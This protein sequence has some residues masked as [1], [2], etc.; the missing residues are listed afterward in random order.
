MFSALLF[1]MC[2]LGI[3]TLLNYIAEGKKEEEKGI[4]IALPFL[5]VL[6]VCMYSGLFMESEVM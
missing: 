1:A 2:Q 3:F 4:V 5:F 6:S